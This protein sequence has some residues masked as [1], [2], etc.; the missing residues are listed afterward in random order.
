MQDCSSRCR[1][2]KTRLISWRTWQRPDAAFARQGKTCRRRPSPEPNLM[3]RGADAEGR[4][5][6][7]SVPVL[8]QNPASTL[9]EKKALAAAMHPQPA[10]K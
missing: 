9:Q 5:G 6:I 3:I 1:T 10:D 4:G 7:K 2:C 8:R